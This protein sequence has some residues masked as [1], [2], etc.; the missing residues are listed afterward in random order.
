M[1]AIPLHF[2]PYCVTGNSLPSLAFYFFRL[3]AVKLR[4]DFLQPF[5]SEDP[6]DEVLTSVDDLDV[7]V[8]WFQFH[9]FLNVCTTFA[10]VF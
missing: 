9:L 7:S 2:M 4:V 3:T 10:T 8:R 6:P 5:S 1:H